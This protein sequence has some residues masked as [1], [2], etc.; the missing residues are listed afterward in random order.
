MTTNQKLTAPA[1]GPGREPAVQPS[2]QYERMVAAHLIAAAPGR[3]LENTKAVSLAGATYELY[4]RLAPR[5]AQG[6]ILSLLAV[7]VT[8]A[9]LDCLALAA[10][11]PLEHETVRELNLRFGLKAAAVAADLIKALED[12]HREKS[13]RVSVGAVNVE[14]GGQAIVGNVKS[15]RNSVSSKDV[16]E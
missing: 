3:Y 15:G 9:C 16:P 1:Q 12:R 6:S 2:G 4:E 13:D 8:N 10:R 5:D 11:V 7:S 14:A